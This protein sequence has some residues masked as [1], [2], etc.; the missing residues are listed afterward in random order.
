MFYNTKISEAIDNKMDYSKFKTDYISFG[1][2]ICSL[3]GTHMVTSSKYDEVQLIFHT[4]NKK[5]GHAGHHGLN[6]ASLPIKKSFLKSFMN[7]VIR[8]NRVFTIE[9]FI[10]QIVINLIMKKGNF[11]NLTWS[12]IANS[13]VHTF[14]LIIS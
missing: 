12:I 2:L 11:L 4:V 8:Q 5:A 10:S 6:I 1:S 3:L 14:Q 7:S 13:E 9:S